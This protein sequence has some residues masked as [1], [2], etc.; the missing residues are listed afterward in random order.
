MIAGL[1]IY[2]TM[3]MIKSEVITVNVGLAASMASFLLSAGARGRRFALPHSRTMIH[4]PMG[5]AEGQV[6]DIRSEASQILRIRNNIMKQYSSMTGKTIEQIKK[7][8]N[9]D[10][11]MTAKEA[12]DYGLI[13]QIVKPND[14]LIL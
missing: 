8:L 11:F 13:D 2:D 10:N 3:Q 14:K 4:Q 12:L 6:E 7:D 9:R 1:A 5:G